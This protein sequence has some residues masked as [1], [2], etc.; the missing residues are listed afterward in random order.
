MAVLLAD[1]L[2]YSCPAVLADVDVNIRHLVALR[3]HKALEKQIV[4]NRVNIAQSEAVPGDCS[5]PAASGADGDI[6]FV[7]VLAEVPDDKEIAGE[8]LRFDYVQFSVELFL[9]LFG[10][11]AIPLLR[12]FVAEFGQ[13]FLGR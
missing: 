7:G 11:F 5:Y 8:A 3:V 2:D 13:E 4:S 12:T 10:N 9:D 6:V 1:V